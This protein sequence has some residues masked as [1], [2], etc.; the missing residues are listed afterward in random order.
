MLYIFARLI[1]GNS[2]NKLLNG[3]RCNWYQFKG[4]F[5]RN[6]KCV[7]SQFD[8]RGNQKGFLA[9]MGTGLNQTPQ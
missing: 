4:F 3:H 2:F 6:L 9:S 1:Y 7:L 8:F 5:Q